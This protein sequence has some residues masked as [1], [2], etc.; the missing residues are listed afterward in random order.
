MQII[1]KEDN[2]SNYAKHYTGFK[3]NAINWQVASVDAILEHL[4]G[5]AF[6]AGKDER[7]LPRAHKLLQRCKETLV[8]KDQSE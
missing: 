2:M 7:T 1:N 6:L 4:F 8:L 3:D 5:I